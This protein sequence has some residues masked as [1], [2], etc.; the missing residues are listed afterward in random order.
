MQVNRKKPKKETKPESTLFIS[1]VSVIIIFPEKHTLLS[2]IQQWELVEYRAGRRDHY[3]AAPRSRSH[4][5]QGL[6]ISTLPLEGNT[7]PLTHH[8]L[9]HD[10]ALRG[11]SAGM[12][13]RQV[14]CKSSSLLLQI[15]NWACA[16]LRNCGKKTFALGK[17]AIFNTVQKILLKCIEERQTTSAQQWAGH[18]NLHQ[19][20]WSQKK[21]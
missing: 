20:S 16:N 11:P 14:V 13:T 6:A 8:F 3:P 19:N 12:G 9:I 2:V 18:F 21:L 1:T 17:D 4:C 7:A 10:R 15:N 5:T